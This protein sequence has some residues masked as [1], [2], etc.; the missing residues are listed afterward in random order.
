MGGFVDGKRLV[1]QRVE[2]RLGTRRPGKVE[3]LDGINETD[4]IVVAG[5]QRLQRDNTPVRVIELGRAPGGPP[6]GAPAGAAGTPAAMPS[7]AASGLV[8]GASSPTMASVR[9]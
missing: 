4:T 2:V 8:G 3:I 5:Q 1:T 6:S 9:P 7:Q